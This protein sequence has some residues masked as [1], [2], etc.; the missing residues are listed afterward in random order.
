MYKLSKPLKL[1]VDDRVGR[2]FPVFLLYVRRTNVS[3]HVGPMYDAR[4]KVSYTKDFIS[5]INDF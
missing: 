2:V 5:V 4:A 3:G 1:P